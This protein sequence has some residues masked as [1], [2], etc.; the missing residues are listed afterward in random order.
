[1]AGRFVAV[2]VALVAV[3]VRDRCWGGAVAVSEP[4]RG[5]AAT[6]DGAVDVA[7]VSTDTEGS[8]E[9]ASGPLACSVM[10]CCCSIGRETA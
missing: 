5:V 10:A 7:G 8:V 6:S 9:L 2:E 1:M 4:C 3:L